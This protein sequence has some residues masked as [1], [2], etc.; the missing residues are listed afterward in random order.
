MVKKYKV[1]GWAGL[2]QTESLCDVFA[3]FFMQYKY[4]NIGAIKC[5]SFACAIDNSNKWCYTINTNK[6]IM[7]ERGNK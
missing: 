7:S 5:K 4:T 1:Y 2:M 6:L 3:Q